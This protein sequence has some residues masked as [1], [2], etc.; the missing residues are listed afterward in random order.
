MKLLVAMHQAFNSNGFFHCAPKTNHKSLRKL[1]GQLPRDQA[2][3]LWF[4]KH[5]EMLDHVQP[6]IIWN[7]FALNS[8]GHCPDG[9]SDSCAIGEEARLDFLAYYFNRG[10]QWGKEV[11]TTLWDFATPRRWP[12]TSAAGRPVSHGLTG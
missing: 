6:D 9:S 8:P 10:V 5:R 2:D 3:K 7:D 11:V 1:L 4:D 12:T